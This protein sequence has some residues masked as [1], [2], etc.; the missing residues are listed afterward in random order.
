MSAPSLMSGSA[1]GACF[2]QSD[3]LAPFRHP[4]DEAVNVV[5]YFTG[6]TPRPLGDFDDIGQ[7]RDYGL[8]R[9]I[10]KVSR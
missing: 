5:Y 8:S 6:A 1:P 2:F 3:I 4:G 7:I 10:R 9:S